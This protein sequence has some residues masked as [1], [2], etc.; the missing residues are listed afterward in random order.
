MKTIH[1]FGLAV[2]FVVLSGLVSLLAAPSLPADLVTHWNASGEPDGTMSKLLALWLFPA[3]TAG[4]FVLFAAIP[5]I[6]PLRENIAEFRAYY[7]WFVVIFMGYLFLVHAGIVAFNLGYEFD[8]TA[9]ILVGAAGLFYYVGILLP[10]AEPNWFAGIRT[11]WT[12]SSDEVWDRTHSLGS[13][14]FKLTAVLTLVGLFFGDIAI[15][16]LLVPLLLTA[17]V[18]AV[19]SYYL[20]EQIERESNSASGS[21]L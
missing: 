8:F 17:G 19:Y 15:Y 18:T 14:L 21:D 7:D 10:H 16:F 1:R 4:L 6:G 2:G 11:P 9:L 13:R 20:Y 3:L 12:L 5:R